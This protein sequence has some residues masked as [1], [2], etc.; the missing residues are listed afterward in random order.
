MVATWVDLATLN[1]EVNGLNGLPISLIFDWF[2]LKGMYFSTNV[3]N[4]RRF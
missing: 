2:E 3:W 1:F 4:I